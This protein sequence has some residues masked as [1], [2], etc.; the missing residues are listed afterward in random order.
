M[1]PLGPELQTIQRFDQKCFWSCIHTK[2]RKKKEKKVENQ[3]L[4]GAV[5]P[6]DAENISLPEQISKLMHT[7]TKSTAHSV[8]KIMK[9]KKKL[10]IL[11][12]R[13]R[14]NQF[15]NKF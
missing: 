13:L 3:Q 10:C 11:R 1:A 8:L 7:V 12:Q 6:E 4:Y 5:F 15:Q 9:Y 14:I 2:K